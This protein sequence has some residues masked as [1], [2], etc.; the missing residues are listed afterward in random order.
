M[1]DPVNA[2]FAR[3]ELLKSEWDT[4]KREMTSLDPSDPVQSARR[5]AINLRMH[6]ITTDMAAVIAQTRKILPTPDIDDDLQPPV[7]PYINPHHPLQLVQYSARHL[8]VVQRTYDSSSDDDVPT[9]HA[10]DLDLPPQLPLPQETIT[11]D[12]DELRRNLMRNA[13]SDDPVITVEGRPTPD[14]RLRGL[15]HLLMDKL[16]LEPSPAAHSHLTEDDREQ[17]TLELSRLGRELRKLK[18]IPQPSK[19]EQKKLDDLSARSANLAERLQHTAADA[20]GKSPGDAAG[21]GTPAMPHAAA[22]APAAAVNEDGGVG[23]GKSRKNSMFAGRHAKSERGTSGVSGGQD[24]SRDVGLTEEEMQFE[25]AEDVLPKSTQN[26]GNSA[27]PS[28]RKKGWMAFEAGVAS[29][30]ALGRS[31]RNNT[32]SGRGE[33]G[34]SPPGADPMSPGANKPPASA[35]ASKSRAAGA[36]AGGGG[37]AFAEAATRIKQRGEK[38]DAAADGSEQMANDAGDMLSAARALRQ[39]NHKGGL[40]S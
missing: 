8:H 12:A 17:I 33:G 19:Q 32:L 21:S 7:S 40:F 14:R 5:D 28:R 35:A 2:G 18:R 11:V 38:L 24:V 39:R 31:V 26:L 13:T 23:A 6:Q 3:S 4:L 10:D 16:K 9:V 27:A 20:T 22:A 37:N 34:K 36:E 25:A 29:I 15:G 30:R 1:A